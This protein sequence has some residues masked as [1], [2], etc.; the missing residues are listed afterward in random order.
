VNKI[1]G[2]WVDWDLAFAL[3]GVGYTQF[4]FP[5]V[6]IISS[7]TESMVSSYWVLG[8][9]IELLKMAGS[10]HLDCLITNSL[11][12]EAG[13]GASHWM[14]R[15]SQ[16]PACPVS[17]WDIQRPRCPSSCWSLTFVI[18]S[19]H[20]FILFINPHDRKFVWNPW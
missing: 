11:C 19:Y 10:T 4:D 17:W 1:A 8:I 20:L 5:R 13:R 12:V 15:Y 6:Q 7:L 2:S 16:N 3:C 9:T 14:Q 18:I